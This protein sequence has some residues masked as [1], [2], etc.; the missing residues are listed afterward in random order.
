MVVATRRRVGRLK[1]PAPSKIFQGGS[2][3][4]FVSN[5]SVSEEKTLGSA[6]KKK[7]S[8]FAKFLLHLT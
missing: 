7:D 3:Q 8:E 6:E 1:L 4:K 2:L 5:P